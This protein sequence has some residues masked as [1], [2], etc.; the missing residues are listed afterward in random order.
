MAGKG[1]AGWLQLNI[2]SS[3]DRNPIEFGTR[4]QEDNVHSIR[5]AVAVPLKM[6]SATNDASS[7]PLLLYLCIV[8]CLSGFGGIANRMALQQLLRM[9]EEH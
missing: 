6:T 7:L 9:I 4:Q 2:S 3:S 8:T 1:G 5:V